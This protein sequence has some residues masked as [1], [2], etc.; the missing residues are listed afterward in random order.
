M[1]SN[2]QDIAEFMRMCEREFGVSPSRKEAE[3]MLTEL[4]ELYEQ[5]VRPPIPRRS[6]RSGSAACRG[7][8]GGGSRSST[9]GHL[10][11]IS[12]SVLPKESRQIPALQAIFRLTDSHDSQ[13]P[14]TDT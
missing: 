5:L 11:R 6:D 14:R 9:R 12:E 8:S 1:Q 7:C 2:D 4:N 10:K 3:V 13:T